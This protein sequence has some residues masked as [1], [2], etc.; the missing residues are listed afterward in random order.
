LLCDPG[1]EVLVPRPSYPLFDFLADIQDVTLHRY[2]LFYDHGWH[3]DIAGLSAATSSRT[4]A[5]LVVNPNNPT[6]SY[7]RAA[8]FRELEAFCAERNLALISDEVFLDYELEAAAE[9]S[10]AFSCAGLSFALS[11]ISKIS[12]LPQMKAAWMVVSGPEELRHQAHQ[13]LEVI[14]DAY[15]SQNAPVQNALATLLDQRKTM[16]PQLAERVR[17][18]L[19][20]LDRQLRAAPQIERLLVEGGWYVVLRVPARE[21]DEDL[22]VELIERARIVVHPGHFY[23]FQNDGYLVVSL[24]P[25]ASE[26][27]EGVLALLSETSGR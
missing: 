26:F 4:R 17:S 9:A 27:Q 16:Q 22:A 11:G 10:A 15:L 2:D 14:A 21:S 6:G 13:R 18:N 23:E 1:D 5:V 20:F 19:E 7:V 25:P 12:C 3:V 24:I 8:E